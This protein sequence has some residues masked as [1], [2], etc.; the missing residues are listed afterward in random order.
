MQ[1]M[2]YHNRLVGLPKAFGRFAKMSRQAAPS[3]ATL[4][5]QDL[6]QA[7]QVLRAV[8][9]RPSAPR[10]PFIRR[11]SHDDGESTAAAIQQTSCSR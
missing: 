3:C 10:P 9:G 5:V 2:D 7:G 4:R 1:R 11:L 8:L 6:S